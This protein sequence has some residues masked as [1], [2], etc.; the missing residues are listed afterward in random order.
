MKCHVTDNC[1]V[2]QIKCHVTNKL[3]IHMNLSNTPPS[4]HYLSYFYETRTD[5]NQTWVGSITMHCKNYMYITNTSQVNYYLK[6]LLLPKSVLLY[7]S[8]NIEVSLKFCHV[9]NSLTIAFN[10]NEFLKNRISM[11]EPF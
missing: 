10:I 8:I 1:H 5:S 7:Y 4:L 11:F 2:I 3:I 9:L 6:I